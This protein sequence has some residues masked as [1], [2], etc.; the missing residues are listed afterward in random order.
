MS[1]VFGTARQSFPCTSVSSLA[2]VWH[3]VPWHSSLVGVRTWIRYVKCV[4]RAGG[5]RRAGSENLAR[6]PGGFVKT[7]AGA[8]ISRPPLGSAPR[9][10]RATALAALTCCFFMCCVSDYAARSISA[11]GPNISF[12]FLPWPCQASADRSYQELADKGRCAGTRRAMPKQLHAGAAAVEGSWYLD[13]MGTA[14]GVNLAV[15]LPS[16]GSARAVGM[17]GCTGGGFADGAAAIRT[18][19]GRQLHGASMA[20]APTT[21]GS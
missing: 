16:P 14:P 7:G 13:L 8:A 5:H 19:G 21:G 3:L 15:H 12:D 6:R 11:Q 9:V 1:C 20:A 10:S 2:F 4:D 17:A 18:R